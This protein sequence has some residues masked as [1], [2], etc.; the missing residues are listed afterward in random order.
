[1][2]EK[3][4]ERVAAME[5]A[6]NACTAATQALDAQ[7]ARMDALREETIA[8]FRYYGSE[9]WHRDREA[10]LPPD[11][12]AGVLSEDAAYDAYTALRNTAFHM[13][14]LGTDILKNRI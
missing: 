14:E 13:L 1:M 8:L 10:A 6:L 11:L 7:L 2:D 9:D 5:R 12:P 3:N 4:I